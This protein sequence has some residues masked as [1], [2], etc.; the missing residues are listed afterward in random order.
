MSVSK[1]EQRRR[2][3]RWCRY[4][5]HGKQVSQGNDVIPWGF[6][7]AAKPVCRARTQWAYGWS[8]RR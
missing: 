4:V 5:L 8:P 3:R 6:V 1:I 2:Y 7:R